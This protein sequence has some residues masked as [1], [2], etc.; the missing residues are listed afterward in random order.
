[1]KATVDHLLIMII[2][3]LYVHF[4]DT[5]K[6]RAWL[7]QPNLNFGGVS[8]VWLIIV[9]KGKKVLDFVQQRELT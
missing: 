1:M 5:Q 4:N 8:P 9:G 7:Y 2:I 6:V 3:E